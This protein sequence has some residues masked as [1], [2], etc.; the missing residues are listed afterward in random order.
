[1]YNLIIG[2][3]PIWYLEILIGGVGIWIETVTLANDLKVSTMPPSV[4]SDKWMG[5][6]THSLVGL[7]K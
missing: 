7:T 6:L 3:Q 4:V 2:V 5:Q 1:V